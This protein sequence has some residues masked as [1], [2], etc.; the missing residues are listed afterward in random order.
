MLSNAS[1]EVIQL[2]PGPHHHSD[3]DPNWTH[4]WEIVAAAH[5][6][7][8]VEHVEVRECDGP[9]SVSGLGLGTT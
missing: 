9:T 8:V 1:W 5:E 2:N 6:A 3:Q 4:S 7:I